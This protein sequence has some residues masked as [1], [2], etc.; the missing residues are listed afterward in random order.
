MEQILHVS[1]IPICHSKYI[2]EF[3][4]QI[5][6]G[7]IS[8]LKLNLKNEPILSILKRVFSYSY[9]LRNANEHFENP[10]IKRT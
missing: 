8:Y 3:S 7:F 10:N 6:P 1:N 4:L 5:I 2:I 9:M